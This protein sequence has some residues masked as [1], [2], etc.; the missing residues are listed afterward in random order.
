M[1]DFFKQAV[2]DANTMML[3]GVTVGQDIVRR[4]SAGRIEQLA[5]ALHA[6]RES[7]VQIEDHHNEDDSWRDVAHDAALK[8]TEALK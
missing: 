7:L 3:A 6:A 1:N 8:I 2:A 5:L 4:E